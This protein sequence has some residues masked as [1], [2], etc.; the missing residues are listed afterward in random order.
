M[1]DLGKINENLFYANGGR[2]ETPPAMTSTTTTDANANQVVDDALELKRKELANLQAE[3]E[4]TE[5]SRWEEVKEKERD[6]EEKRILLEKLSEDVAAAR[7]KIQGIVRCYLARTDLDR[8]VTYLTNICSHFKGN[9]NG[10][11]GSIVCFWA[12]TN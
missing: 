1:T 6:L 10:Y 12:F 8:L 2:A 3:L 5:M 4:R 11:G 9:K 7:R